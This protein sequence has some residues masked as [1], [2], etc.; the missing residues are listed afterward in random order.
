VPD[1]SRRHDVRA[2][3]ASELER[4]RRGLQA[5]LALIRPDSPTRESILAQ[6]KA[7][8]AELAERNPEGGAGQVTS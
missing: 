8:D 2:L 1:L 4:A 7:V 6:L 3:T 5:S